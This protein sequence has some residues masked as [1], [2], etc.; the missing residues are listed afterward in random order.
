M[1]R[2][3]LR[4]SPQRVA[5]VGNR[6]RLRS[7]RRR[8]PSA[9]P[10]LP[11]GVERTAAGFSAASVRHSLVPAAAEESR[12][13]LPVPGPVGQAGDSE[14]VRRQGQAVEWKGWRMT[15][16]GGLAFVGTIVTRGIRGKRSRGRRWRP[17]YGID[18]LWC[19]RSSRWLR[20]HGRRCR[21]RGLPDGLQRRSVCGSRGRR[22]NGTAGGCR[23]RR[24]RLLGTIVTRG[25]GGKGS[26]GRRWRPAYGIDL[27]RSRRPGRWL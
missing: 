11:A 24:A 8:Q 15:G 27:L 17:A 18:V 2:C 16:R 19:R 20:G 4:R 7:Q 3:R 14:P 9:A 25:I 13:A 23:T 6:P 21:R 5:C 22:S 26:C 10:A 12:P 1:L